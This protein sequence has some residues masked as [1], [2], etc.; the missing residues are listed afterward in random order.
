MHNVL[1]IPNTNGAILILPPTWCLYKWH[2]KVGSKLTV[3]SS[4]N[5]ILYIVTENIFLVVLLL[6]WLQAW[7]QSDVQSLVVD[8]RT[9]I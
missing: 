6:L 2:F 4:D 1:S 3:V 9:S 5:K 8:Y 7:Q